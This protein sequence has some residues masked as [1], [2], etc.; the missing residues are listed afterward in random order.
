[1][2]RFK[3]LMTEDTFYKII[4]SVRDYKESFDGIVAP[5]L[6]GEPLLDQRLE[7]FIEYSK[8]RLPR[9]K[10]HLY[11][12]GETLTVERYLALKYAGTDVFH[13]SIHRPESQPDILHVLSTIGAQYP[14]LFSVVCN[15]PYNAEYLMN[16]G[17]LVQVNELPVLD[18]QF[19][20]CLCYKDLVF[21][22]RGNA[23]LCCNDYLGKHLFGNIHTS[24]VSDIWK[25]V[26]NSKIRNA[27][28]F[29]YLPLDICR[30][31]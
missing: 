30:T 26:A 24:S 13:V 4:D 3:E 27:L 17:G 10:I 12:N 21:D 31:I 16:R 22:V 15:T 14:E 5:H 29:G 7:K 11:T 2:P 19:G 6:Y 20:R 28:L 23:V 18:T 25:S 1:V 9:A 8:T